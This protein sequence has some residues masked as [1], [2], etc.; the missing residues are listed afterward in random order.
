MPQLF[1]ATRIALVADLP[2]TATVYER[3]ARQPFRD[4][5]LTKS[6]ARHH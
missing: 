5:F 3:R 4:L 6:L 1:G 2:P